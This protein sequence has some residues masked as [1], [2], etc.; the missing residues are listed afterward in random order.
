MKKLMMYQDRWVFGTGN[1]GDC[2]VENDE[3]WDVGRMYEFRNL[4]ICS[5]ATL[6][7]CGCWIARIKVQDCFENDWVVDMRRGYVPVCC[8]T[9]EWFE[10]KNTDWCKCEDWVWKWWCW[11]LWHW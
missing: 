9:V 5:G 4:K 1:D 10:L 6:R 3:I 11:G 2:I 7:F 8:M